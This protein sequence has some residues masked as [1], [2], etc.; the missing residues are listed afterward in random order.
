MAQQRRGLT[1]IEKDYLKRFKAIWAE[2]K[3]ALNLTQEAV[4]LACGW[5]GQTAFSQYY[6]GVVP[7]NIEAV[8]RLSK[9]LQV[10][11]SEIMPEIND[12]LPEGR[13]GA[14]ATSDYQP[15]DLALAKMINNLPEAQRVALLNVATAFG[16]TSKEQTNDL[17]QVP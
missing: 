5:S 8:L 7:L 13:G 16:N 4:G 15:K 6:R 12:L 14:T 9:I 2:K 10:H 17:N 11:P 3:Q 1:A